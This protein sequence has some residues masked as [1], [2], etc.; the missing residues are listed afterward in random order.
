[1]G[2]DSKGAG[3]HHRSGSIQRGEPE[4]PVILG[5]QKTMLCRL[6]PIEYMPGE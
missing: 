6:T 4:R 3:A 5:G 1:M 2:Y